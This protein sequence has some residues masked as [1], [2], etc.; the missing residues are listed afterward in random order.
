M[1]RAFFRCLPLKEVYHLS[2]P[3]QKAKG[4]VKLKSGGE[5]EPGDERTYQ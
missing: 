5:A 4:A 1:A 3:K 2:G